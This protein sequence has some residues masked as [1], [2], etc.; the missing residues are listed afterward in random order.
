MKDKSILTLILLALVVAGFACIAAVGFGEAK[1]LG[2]AS[3]RR[4]LDLNGGVSILYEARTEDTARRDMESAL[5][6]IRGRLAR[7]GIGDYTAALEG[8]AG[9]RVEIPGTNDDEAAAKEIGRSAILTFRDEDGAILLDGSGI[10]NAQRILRSQTQGGPAEAV[11]AIE[12]TEEGQRLFEEATERNIGKSLV[13]M[14]DNEIIS[15]PQ[16]SEK[17]T[18][19]NA[20]IPGSFTTA[21]ADELAALIR[22]GSLPVALDTVGI[23]TIGAKLGGGATT[24][25]LAA[26]ITGF[27]LILIIMIVFYRAFGAAADWALV[28]FAGI[29]LVAVSWLR[30]T[31]TLPGAAGVLLSL[32][33]A[34]DANAAILERTKEELSSGKNLA[35]SVDAGFKKAFPSIIDGGAAALILSAALLLLGAGPIKNFAQTLMIGVIAAAFTSLAVTR[36]VIYCLGGLGASMRFAAKTDKPPKPVKQFNILANKNKFFIVSGIVL[37]VGLLAM[38]LN[39]VFGNGMFNYGAALRGEILIS[40][41]AAAGVAIIG[42]LV[43]MSLRY[44][45]VKVGAGAVIP[46]LHD[47]LF[48]V[49]CLALFRVPFDNSFF[50]VLLAA[51][52]FAAVGKTVL[53]DRLR[54]NKRLSKRAAAGELIE[55]SA[56]QSV[57]RHVRA[58][59]AAFLI[60]IP[61]IITGFPSFIAFTLL[62]ALGILF[63]AYS[64]VCV[65]GPVYYVLESKFKKSSKA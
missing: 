34:V 37:A 6:I 7:S 31:L 45:S 57:R 12:F 24:A 19:S 16:V 52:G 23:E 5:S 32:V 50:A 29:V 11:V 25:L 4:G 1:T 63:A 2:V 54:E 30:V 55:K 15:A 42:I 48:A 58:A 64:A 44:R 8:E 40:Y 47:A 62:T 28:I 51:T 56:N 20:L 17:I 9:I 36:A 53:F 27:C 13:I 33:I 60:I 46:M 41:L 21:V 18:G 26:A 61:L 3:I 43:Y 22:A 14:L 59:A 65:A 35:A 10:I 38:A 49:G 39:G